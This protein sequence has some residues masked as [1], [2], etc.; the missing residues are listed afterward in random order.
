MR[1]FTSF[2]AAI[3]LGLTLCCLPCPPA[4]AENIIRIA[5]PYIPTEIHPLASEEPINRILLQNVASSLVRAD[6]DQLV[7]DLAAKIESSPTQERWTILINREARAQN[8]FA[9]D[10]SFVQKSFAYYQQLAQQLSQNLAASPTPEVTTAANSFRE[11]HDH[12]QRAIPPYLLDKILQIK[13]HE[14]IP[15][16]A[17]RPSSY[18]LELTAAQSHFAKWVLTLPL[19][20][21]QQA[22]AFGSSLGQ[23]TNVVFAGPYQM[24]E[25]RPLQ[26][27]V[28]RAND[29]YYRPTFPRTPL[30]E[31]R[32]FAQASDALSALRTGAIDL[33]P[34]PTDEI[35]L[36]SQSDT[37][38]TQQESPLINMQ[39]SPKI[40]TWKLFRTHWSNP[41]NDQDK[42]R[43]DLV[44]IRKTLQS[45]DNFRLFFDLTGCKSAL[46]Y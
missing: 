35:I 45:D 25:N 10:E 8:K 40:S 30:V 14:V 13:K 20:N 18:Q 37:V 12:L 9:V 23:G 21:A 46:A 5:L 22:Q 3:V 4:R 2:C 38:I 16:A 27:I 24:V 43:T 17:N 41:E 7:L 26:V 36:E 31:F 44:L 1:S 15:A 42:L 28:L 39:Q 6:K 19:I 29:H 11:F 33:I 32:Y 34:L